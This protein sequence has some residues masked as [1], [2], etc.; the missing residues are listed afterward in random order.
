MGL[1]WRSYVD[2]FPAQPRDTVTNR[3]NLTMQFDTTST[4]P[5]YGQ[6]QNRQYKT[7]TQITRTKIVDLLK[8]KEIIY[9]RY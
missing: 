9:M 2:Q 6:P 5:Q 7:C 4:Q 1:V 8:E 3:V